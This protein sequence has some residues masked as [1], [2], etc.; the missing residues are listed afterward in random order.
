M[1]G[2]QD[3]ALQHGQH[4]SISNEVATITCDTTDVVQEMR[5]VDNEWEGEMIECETGDVLD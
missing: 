3:L 1:V 2:C 5:C 4:I